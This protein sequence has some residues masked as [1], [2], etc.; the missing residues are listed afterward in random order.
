MIQ[1]YTSLCQAS[2]PVPDLGRD[3]IQV[4]RLTDM[5]NMDTRH[6]VDAHSLQQILLDD[7]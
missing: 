4:W 5:F 7:N 3:S 2:D 6:L 1:M